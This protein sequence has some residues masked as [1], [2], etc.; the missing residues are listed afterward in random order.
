VLCC[1]S[2]AVLAPMAPLD[3]SSVSC[4]AFRISAAHSD[5]RDKSHRCSLKLSL[6]TCEPPCWPVDF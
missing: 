5:A 2:G 1:Q 4:P 6:T 3:P